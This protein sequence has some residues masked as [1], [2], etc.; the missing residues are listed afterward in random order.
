MPREETLRQYF[1]HYVRANGG[2]VYKLSAAGRRGKPDELVLLPWRRP[3]LVE[4]KKRGKQP[5]AHQTR[6][7]ARLGKIG[8][9]VIVIDQK[10]QCELY[11]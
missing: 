4:L 7:F 9:Q 5:E 6:E 8:H 10:E 11:L 1:L 2:R 3:L